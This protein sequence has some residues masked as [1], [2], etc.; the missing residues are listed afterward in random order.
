MAAV[1]DLYRKRFDIADKYFKLIE[2]A[3]ARREVEYH[4][5]RRIKSAWLR[6]HARQALAGENKMALRIQKVFRQ[7]QARLFVEF[8]KYEKSRNC[9]VIYFNIMARRLQSLWRG[10]E[11]R[12]KVF[13]WRKFKECV[14]GKGQEEKAAACEGERCSVFERMQGRDGWVPKAHSLERDFEHCLVK[15]VETFLRTLRVVD[16]QN[17]G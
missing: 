2:K 8:L 15:E 6:H 13:S 14:E 16:G 11:V 10:Y 17:G 4:A 9:R 3:Q 7:R 12:S 1:A 5:A